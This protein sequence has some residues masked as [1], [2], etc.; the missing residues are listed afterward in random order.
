M[1]LVS[2]CSVTPLCIRSSGTPSV[3]SSVSVRGAPGRQLLVRLQRQLDVA[4]LLGLLLGVDLPKEES[5]S[6]RSPSAR[7]PP[8]RYQARPPKC[9]V[10]RSSSYL[11]CFSRSS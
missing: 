7:R 11:P 6:T 8:S 3:P 10:E 9:R 4:R 5:M 2:R 1:L